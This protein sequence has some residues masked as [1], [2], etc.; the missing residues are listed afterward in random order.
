VAVAVVEQEQILPVVVAVAERHRR[1]RCKS[2]PRG[3]Q[4]RQQSLLARVGAGDKAQQVLRTE[5]TRRSLVMQ[6]RLRLVEDLVD[7]TPPPSPMGALW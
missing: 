2:T 5:A 4:R 6:L 1:R 7:I 3:Q